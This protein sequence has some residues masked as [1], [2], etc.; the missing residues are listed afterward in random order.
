[1][2]ERDLQP[3]CDMLDDVWGL[4]PQAKPPSEGQKAMFFRALAEHTIA[5]VRRA[6]DAHVKDKTRGKFPPLPADI[7][8]Q[9]EGEAANDGRPG[10]EEAWA[11]ALQSADEAATVVWT[12]EIAQA[13]GIARVIYA[14]GDEV[15]ARMAFKESYTR[16]LA[17][18]RKGGVAPQWT[19][20]LGHDAERRDAAL[21]RA[22]IAGYLPKPE[23][24]RQ[25]PAP[26]HAMSPRNRRMPECVRDR[27]ADFADKLRESERG[28]REWADRLRAREK[29]GEALTEAERTM[30]RNAVE[31]SSAAGDGQPLVF[32]PIAN[33][34]LPPGMQKGA[35][36]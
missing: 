33:E 21:D 2:V 7:I 16:L 3:F 22:H 20:S 8:F 13:W 17:E 18:A 25:L 28:G 23:P 9:I 11:I 27:I 32:N 14:E 29:A 36:A 31:G 26:D 24:L 19:A 30:W 34:L 15:G 35:Q 12:N 1:M 6:F 4:Y 5:A 10:A